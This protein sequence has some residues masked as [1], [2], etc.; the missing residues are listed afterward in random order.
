MKRIHIEMCGRITERQAR[1]LM[2]KRPS[3]KTI[4]SVLR[5]LNLQTAFMT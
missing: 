2:G 4:M 3:D 1:R 5:R